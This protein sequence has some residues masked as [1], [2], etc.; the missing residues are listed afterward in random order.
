MKSKL[1][2]TLALSGMLFSG[3][4]DWLDVN[5]NPNNATQEMVTSDMLLTYVEQN[6]T[7]QR[8]SSSGY[9]HMCQ[10]LTK[11]GD[12]SGNY[13]FL[14]GSIMPQNV[15]TFWSYRYERMANLI[16]I[17]EKALEAGDPGYN[18]IAST[19][20]VIDFRELVDMFGNIPYTEALKAAENLAP[21][22]DKGAD[23]YNGLINDIEEAIQH[24]DEALADKTYSAPGLK[25]S[26]ILF[27][28]NLNKW[29]QYAYSIELSLLMRISNVQDVAAKV[30]AIKDK[31]L[32]A[33]DVVTANPGYYKASAKMNPNYEAWGYTYL[34]REATNHKQYVPTAILIDFLRDNND[35]RLRVYASPR[36]RLGEDPNPGSEVNYGVF[37]LTNEYYIGVPYGQLAPA[38]GNYACKIGLGVLGHSSS[39]VD[40]PTSEMIVMSGSLVSFYLAEAA[41][42][43]MIP[44]GDAA[45]KQYYEE[46]VAGAFS[47]YE[48][49]LQDTG[50]TNAGI[51]APIAGSAVEAA[52][53]Y[54]AQDNKNVNWDLMTSTEEK[55]CAIQTQ[56]WLSLFM[57]D[58][59]EAWSEQRRTDYPV[60]QAS[61]C[62]AKGSKLIARFPYPDSEKNLN[63]VNHNAEGEI[64]VYTSLVFWDLKNEDVK[65]TE[66]YQ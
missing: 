43:N 6:K 24:F 36:N 63:P 35:P 31:C 7:E 13:T 47:M 44:G 42:R 34:D 59:L 62:Q 64:D 22:Y 49:P 30:N 53:E 41:L 45:A 10:H 33:N 37:G 20:M 19:L 56:K 14:T 27:A 58:P 48:K 23:V 2:Y 4:S 61:N 65:R 1:I 28:G 8:T 16:A 9:H 51:K 54:L 18:A 57:V 29:K 38:G 25:K 52:Q 26:D 21:K 40:G 46:G 32:N 17:K 12:Y 50:F 66:I 15:N 55:M 60:L 11:S 5:H 3:C 39:M